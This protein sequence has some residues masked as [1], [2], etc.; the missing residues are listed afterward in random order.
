MLSRG[1]LIAE[2]LGEVRGHGDGDYGTSQS[3]VPMSPVPYVENRS[4]N[5]GSAEFE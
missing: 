1:R 2:A 3:H 5:H 4:L